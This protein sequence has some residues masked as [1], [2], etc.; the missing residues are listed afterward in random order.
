MKSH[1]KNILIYYIG[2]VKIKKD[3][4]ISSVNPMYLIF[5]E[6]TGYFDEINGN[7]YL[8][9]VP[10]N[11]SKDKTKKYEERWIK[12]RDLISPVNKKSDD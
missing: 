2:Y 1:T 5:K 4:K 7:Q 8:T 3:I 9:L 12:I 6:M 11:E 10:I